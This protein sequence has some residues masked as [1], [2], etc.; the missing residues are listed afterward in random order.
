M[1]TYTLLDLEYWSKEIETMI[2]KEGL[3]CYLQEFEL[4]TLEDMMCIQ[5]YMGLPTHYS[6]WSFGKAYMRLKNFYEQG[7]QGVPYEI[8]IHSDPCIAYLLKNNSL[9]LQILTMAHVYGH[10]DFFKNNRLYQDIQPKRSIEMFH[11]YRQRLEEYREHPFVGD[12]RVESLLDRA[13]SIRWQCHE[14][15][16]L[17]FFIDHGNLE[18]WEKEVLYIIKEETR[19]FK[20]QIETKIIN[21]GWATW[22]HYRICNQLLFQREDLY[23]EFLVHHNQITAPRWYEVNPY[24]LGFY[25][26][27]KLFQ[28]YGTIEKLFEIRRMERDVSF[29]R[30][31]LTEERCQELNL[32]LYEKNKKKY[33]PFKKQ[34]E[35]NIAKVKEQLLLSIGMEGIPCIQPL[36][37]D[38]KKRVLY[39]KHEYDGREL[40]FMY[41]SETLKYIAGLWKGKVILRTYMDEKKQ[42]LICEPDKKI[43]VQNK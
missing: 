41:A 3:D 19:Y 25:L 33:P 8:V 24:A 40:D 29:I 10:N 43:F 11:T 20:P 32:F 7:L 21:E 30:K 2:I 4:V 12:Q 28:Q 6:H 5:A 39:L 42:Q 35:R 13:H 15:S 1:N 38:I 9:V 14:E 23:L 31:Y 36:D 37:W 17:Q 22:W 18:E 26:F 16:L 34:E 27:E